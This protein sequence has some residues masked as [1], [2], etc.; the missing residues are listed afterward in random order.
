MII[1]RTKNFDI[2]DIIGPQVA[3][4]EP[5]DQ[6][7]AMMIEQ[8]KMQRAM[9]MNQRQ[10]QKLQAEEAQNRVK[11]LQT[12]QKVAAQKDE[13]DQKNRIQA[14]TL[15]SKENEAKNVGLYKTRSTIIPPVSMK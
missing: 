1:L 5:Q 4:P 8:M 10:R 14:K 13:A 3:A 2:P 15:E 12:A 9:M 7:Q 11:A 6:S